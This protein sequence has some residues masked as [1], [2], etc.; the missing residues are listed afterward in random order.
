[1]SGPL[2]CN[3]LAMRVLLLHPGAMGS[4]L[5]AVL[6]TNGHEVRWVAADRS[7]STHQRAKADGFAAMDDIATGVMGAEVVLSVCPPEFA[8]DVAHQVADAG[9]TGLFVDA[10]AVSPDSA[11]GA[12]STIAGAGATMVDGG[13]IGP[14]VRGGARN[15]LYL[16]G[17][18]NDVATV[19]RLFD[20]TPVETVVLD[21][22]IGG[23]SA[24]K[25]AFAGWTKGSSALLLAVRA[26]ATAEGVTEGLDH[27]W[28]TMLPHLSEQLRRAAV[29][30]APKAW[31][32]EAEMREIAATLDS[33]GLPAGFHEAAADVYA[34]LAEFRDS[35]DV[36]PDEVIERLTH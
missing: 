14:P 18:A 36:N 4:S 29:G 1:V 15:L 27:A 31:R 35:T 26:M 33:V 9:F 3:A 32:F 20:G 6:I 2:G 21:A 22:P 24:T 23:A 19:A 7:D 30:S 11:R 28:Q 13:I 10:N 16:S 12:A 25:M 8:G 34:R 5:G 17:D